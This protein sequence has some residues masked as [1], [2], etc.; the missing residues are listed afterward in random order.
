MKINLLSKSKYLGVSASETLTVSSEM[1]ERELDLLCRRMC[2]GGSMR[3]GGKR[4][5]LALEEDE[6][7]GRVRLGRILELE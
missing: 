7:V 3:L 2:A 5:V 1:E 6:A 4:G